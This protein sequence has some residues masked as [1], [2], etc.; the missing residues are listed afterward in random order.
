M[1]KIPTEQLACRAGTANA[2]NSISGEPKLPGTFAKIFVISS[3]LML[4]PGCT[5]S[6]WISAVG[7]MADAR[8]DYE[9]KRTLDRLKAANKAVS[10]K[11]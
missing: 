3:A 8:D 6:S 7:A 4:M 9:K 5:T 10:K 1:L 2:N 11:K